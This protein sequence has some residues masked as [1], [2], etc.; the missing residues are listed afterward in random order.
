MEDRAAIAALREC[1]L[2][3]SVSDESLLGIARTLRKRRFRR[4]E[5]IFHQG[6]V[7]D[8][9]EIVASGS[10]K[11]VLASEGGEEAILATVQPSQTFGELALLDGA[12]RSASAIALEPSETWQLPRSTLRDLMDDDPALRDALF[13]SLATVLRRITG[14]VEELHFLDLAGRLATRL[15][16]LARAQ[17][18]EAQQVTLDWHLTQ[19]DLAAMIGG[20]RQSV[21]RLLNDLV[22]E[23]LVRVDK[24]SLV[25]LDVDALLRRRPLTT[26]S[27]PVGHADLWHGRAGG[28]GRT[29]SS[30]GHAKRRLSSAM[31]RPGDIHGSARGILLRRERVSG[32][33]VSTGRYRM[34][35][36]KMGAEGYSVRPRGG[37]E[38]AGDDD[39]EGHMR[40][41]A[42]ARQRRRRRGPR[43]VRTPRQRRRDVEGHGKSAPARQRRR[44]R[45]GPR[46][47][48]TRA[49]AT[50]T[51]SRATASPHPR[52]SDDDDVEGHGK[53]AAPLGSR[54][55]PWRSL[56]SG[57]S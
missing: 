24:D 52:A 56:P 2:F 31:C 1:A 38:I 3:G 37:G 6:D 12:P 15:G 34:P 17:D 46:Q 14:Q 47:V 22:D 53:S 32:P 13:A 40:K 21:N 35:S 20:T 36:D 10:V 26:G 50:T 7:G 45:R 16:R 54:S 43:Q 48:R 18:P 33:I 51:T 55:T 19:S 29:R 4:G 23:G 5:V 9:L 11:I 42:P 57:R 44:R 28:P 8:T 41:S 39:V 30:A 25:I 49:P 27:G